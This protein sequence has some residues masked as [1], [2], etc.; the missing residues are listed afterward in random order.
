MKSDQKVQIKCKQHSAWILIFC[1]KMNILIPFP[2]FFEILLCVEI[3]L[4]PFFLF[5]DFIHMLIVKPNMSQSELFF[6]PLCM[7]NH[8]LSQFHASELICTTNLGVVFGSSLALISYICP[9]HSISVNALWSPSS[10]LL[11]KKKKTCCVLLLYHFCLSHYHVLPGLSQKDAS[12][13]P[14][15]CSC[16]LFLTSQ[17]E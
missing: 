7:P 8:S 11:Q 5:S 1:T 17:S 3:Q 2:Y 15:I 16:I 13:S 6:L 10:K 4:I 12:S 9:I 14:C